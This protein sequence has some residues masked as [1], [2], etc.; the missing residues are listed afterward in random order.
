MHRR[1]GKSTTTDNL[2]CFGVEWEQSRYA[3][4]LYDR[5]SINN[6]RIEGLLRAYDQPPELDE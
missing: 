4:C 6:Q 1:Q 3:K 5:Q 2:C